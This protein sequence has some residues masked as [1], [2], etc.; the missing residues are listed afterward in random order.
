MK[1]PDTMYKMAP[2]YG[3]AF[4][5]STGDQEEATASTDAAGRSLDVQAQRLAE[6]S[7]SNQPT[8][9]IDLVLHLACSSDLFD[10]FKNLKAELGA[11]LNIRVFRHSSLPDGENIAG[12]WSSLT[13]SPASSTSSAGQADCNL[14]IILKPADF[15][16]PCV[17]KSDAN[18]KL[19]GEI[20]I[21]ALLNSL[22][23]SSMSVYVNDITGLVHKLLLDE[24]LAYLQECLNCQQTQENRLKYYRDNL[25]IESKVLEIAERIFKKQFVPSV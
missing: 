13:D 15:R 22:L 19:T 21:L 18:F 23:N 16:S 8:E 5:K 12:R 7:L 2:I 25:P 14:Q 6:L 9:P 11:R 20:K 24:Y 4:G 1:L 3:K 17:F 10:Y